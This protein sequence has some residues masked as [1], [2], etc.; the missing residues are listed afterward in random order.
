MLSFHRSASRAQDGKDGTFVKQ[1]LSG[2]ALS[3]GLGDASPNFEML[4]GD[5]FRWDETK[6]SLTFNMKM[7]VNGEVKKIKSW[8]M[9][10]CSDTCLVARSSGTG[11]N[12]LRRLSSPKTD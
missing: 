4:Q 5:T 9:L 11:L 3:P 6:S 1:R 2:F 10:Y 12:V 8:D 7:G